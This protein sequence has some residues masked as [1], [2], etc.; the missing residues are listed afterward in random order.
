[1]PTAP[2]CDRL[3]I[4][5]GDVAHL[6]RRTSPN[7]RGH[8][9][10]KANATAKLRQVAYATS[11]ASIDPDC[12]QRWAS[13][14]ARLVLRV[15]DR[16][17]GDMDRR[18]QAIARFRQAMAWPVSAASP[19]STCRRR[20]TVRPEAVVKVSRTSSRRPATRANR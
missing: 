7:H 13:A 4:D 20:A 17:L 2:N 14:N 16:R 5:I 8:W 19:G 12:R 6:L 1:M 10:A 15:P 9:A 11:V 3:T 18:S